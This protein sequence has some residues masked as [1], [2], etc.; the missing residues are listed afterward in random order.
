VSTTPPGPEQ[1]GPGGWQPPSGAGQWEQQ[2]QQQQQ[3]PPG[4][5]WGS[6]PP[7]APET[8]GKAITALVLGI[9]GFLICPVV[10]SVAAIVIGGQARNE[11]RS[12]QGLQ[13]G[14][15]LAKA[16]VILG[17]VSLVLSALFLIGI[18]AF[19][20]LGAESDSGGS[21]GSDSSADP[22]NVIT[23]VSDA[24]GALGGLL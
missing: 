16:G 18:I 17:I 1:P 13:S 14:D 7:R 21:G 9:G 23:F 8:N 15:G 5:Q 12:S 3:Q 11:I 2:Y 20:V 24:L 22:V 6:A 19:G 10:L 4:A